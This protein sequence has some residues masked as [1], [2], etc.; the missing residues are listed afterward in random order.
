MSTEAAIQEDVV[1]EE[2]IP[3]VEES[4]KVELILDEKIPAE[5]EVKSNRD[6][7]MDQITARRNQELSE[8]L[9][10]PIVEEEEEPPVEEKRIP[11]EAAE[12]TVRVDGVESKVTEAEIREYQKQKAADARLEEA[13]AKAQELADREAELVARENAFAAREQEL[14]AAEL[15]DDVDDSEL[16]KDLIAKVFAEDEAGVTDVIKKVRRV[17]QPAAAPTAPEVSDDAVNLAVERTLKGRERKEAIQKFAEAYPTLDSN[18]G[19][20]YAVDAQTIVERQADPDASV[21][22]IIDRAAKHVKQEMAAALGLAV[23]ED[24]SVID[25]K[26]ER[27]AA[28]AGAGPAVKATAAS[29]QPLVAPVKKELTAFE[30]LRQAR[31]QG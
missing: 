7:V 26:A 25:D 3:D 1:G 13:S 11:D 22:D 27:I 12:V 6:T 19:L 18:A 17:Q 20:R 8:E 28:K 31:G 24:T 21:W 9:G 30:Q 23:V 14:A 10:E 4:G 2:E 16:A 15:V 5:P 29:K